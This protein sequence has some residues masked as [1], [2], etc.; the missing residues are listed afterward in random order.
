MKQISII[1]WL[2]MLTGCASEYQSITGEPIEVKTN[3][4]GKCVILEPSDH[5]AC[6]A[7]AEECGFSG[8]CTAQTGVTGLFGGC[9]GLLCHCGRADGSVI[10]D[11]ITMDGLTSK[12]LSNECNGSPEA[13]DIVTPPPTTNTG[14]Y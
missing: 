2:I 7:L 11:T 5:S 4:R 12:D 14:Q 6:D 3:W 8:G 9:V 10:V 13:K 1:F